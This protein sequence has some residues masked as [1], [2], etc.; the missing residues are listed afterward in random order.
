MCYC[1]TPFTAKNQGGNMA[2]GSSDAGKTRFWKNPEPCLRAAISRVFSGGRDD[3]DRIE[4]YE[5]SLNRHW[6]R[7]RL[8]A[9]RSKTVFSVCPKTQDRT[10]LMPY[11][12]QGLCDMFAHEALDGR[13]FVCLSQT[14]QREWRIYPLISDLS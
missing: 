6:E 5:R 1:N 7:L 8:L 13:F 10:E 2:D 3:E 9:P 11:D 14:G 4:K 12:T